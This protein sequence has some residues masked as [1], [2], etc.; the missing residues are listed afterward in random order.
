ML[1]WCRRAYDKGLCQGDTNAALTVALSIAKRM[2]AERENNMV[3]AVLKRMGNLFDSW[4]AIEHPKVYDQV[5][6]DRET[7]SSM[8]APQMDAVS[9]DE[10]IA[11]L[12]SLA[13]FAPPPSLD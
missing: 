11:K 1:S 7:E 12:Q 9:M 4:M 6:R 2:E 13:A 3:K 10:M 5:L 8:D